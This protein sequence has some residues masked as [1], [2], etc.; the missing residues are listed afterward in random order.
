MTDQL[1]ALMQ[2]HVF[3]EKPFKLIDFQEYFLT[4]MYTRASLRANEAVT[5]AYGVLS[6]YKGLIV[7]LGALKEDLTKRI[8]ESVSDTSAL[9]KLCCYESVDTSN[10]KNLDL[11]IDM[12]LRLLNALVMLYESLSPDRLRTVKMHA[13]HMHTVTSTIIY[14]LRSSDQKGMSDLKSAHEDL[15]QIVKINDDPVLSVIPDVI[16]R[17]FIEDAYKAIRRVYI[18]YPTHRRLS[19]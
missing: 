7:S 18:H 10:M 2:D 9:S 5:D 15:E 17:D 19:S 1:D 14:A 13:Q 11:A 4:L 6:K 8:Y 16:M 12:A 3:Q